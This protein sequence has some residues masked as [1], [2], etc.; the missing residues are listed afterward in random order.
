M[1]HDNLIVLSSP[2]QSTEKTD[3]D[4]QID[5]I[6]VNKATRKKTDFLEEGRQRMQAISRESQL[7][8][9]DKLVIYISP[10][11]GMLLSSLMSW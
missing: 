5:D 11:C 7:L 4:Y 8:K 9:S 1:R 6:M 2:L 3:E 10:K